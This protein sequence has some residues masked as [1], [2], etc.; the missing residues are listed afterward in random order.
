MF[1]PLFSGRSLPVLIATLL[2]GS[3]FG[4]WVQPVWAQTSPA[5]G[6]QITN[7]GFGSFKAVDAAP[8]DPPVILESNEVVVTVSEVAGITVTNGGVIDDGEVNPGDLVHYRF[9]ITNTGNADTLFFIPDAPASVTNGSFNRGTAPM[10]IIG[11]DPDGA[12]A[13]AAVDLTASNITVPGGGANT[14]TLLG[15]VTAANNGVM[16][17]GATLTLQVP[18]TVAATGLSDGDAITVVMGETTDSGSGTQN[19]PD[20]ADGANTNEI[21]T[22]DPTTG[23]GSDD[24]VNGEREASNSQSTVV[25]IA[26]A[27]NIP[28]PPTSCAFDGNIWYNGP[29]GLYTYNVFSYSNTFQTNLSRTY[30]DIGWGVDGKLYGVDFVSG[31]MR[32]YDI[33]PATGSATLL[34]NAFV[35]SGDTSGGGNS[36][37][38]DEL[39][40]LYFG[41]GTQNHP[42]NARVFRY[43]L[44]TDAAPEL[45]I[46]F[47]DH[48]FAGFP[49]GDFIFIDDF[50]Y[51]AWRP[52]E[53]GAVTNQLL[54]VG[55][56]GPNHEELPSTT[57]TVVGDLTLDNWGLAGNS[58]GNLYVVS[59]NDNSL[60]RVTLAPFAV[61]PIGSLSTQ[62]FGA[63]GLFEAVGIGC[64]TPVDYGDAPDTYGT[65]ASDDSG[66][67]VGPTHTLGGGVY[68]GTF[69]DGETDAATPLDSTGD[70]AEE[71]GITLTPLAEGDTSYTIPAA[72]ITATGTGTLHAWVDFDRSG[73]FEPTEHTSVTVTSGTPA[74]DLSWTGITVAGGDTYARFRLTADTSIDANTPNGAARD[75]EVEDYALVIQP[76]THPAMALVKRITAINGQPTNPNDGT[77]LNVEVNDGIADSDDD[78]SY[79]PANYLMG[80]LN[81]GTIQPG[82]EVEYTIYFLSN[83]DAEA[84][85]VRLCD[86]IQ[87][88]Q[89]FVTGAYSGHD[90]QLEMGGTLYGLTAANDAADRAQLVTVGTLPAGPTCNLPAAA[91][92]IDEGV[93]VVDI[94]GTTGT[95]PGFTTLPFA[96]GPGTPNTAYGFLRFTTRIND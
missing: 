70:G 47:D 63:T 93:L 68:L 46:N 26:A 60:S 15:A 67:G 91:S 58:E 74:A 51:V 12:G 1:T 30:G 8:D 16:P 21:R 90:L 48:G 39:G 94:T 27:I 31:A 29:G 37:S 50:A 73:T 80:E 5:A 83:G 32:L 85:D 20:A 49:S 9:T 72:N 95:P 61:T 59:G 25:A 6:T 22:L 75:G 34:N 33:D 82:D 77:S 28:A 45:W 43:N 2:L 10:Q 4:P 17:A 84:G 3:Q 38:G 53:F 36:L 56:L 35:G 44:Y 87:P 14:A 42:L 19:Q 23:D 62:P 79:W 69:P 78:A 7:K 57:A 86:W 13:G 41:S 71:D 64:S 52:S 65:N 76:G 11:Y 54:R 40:W 89:T 81:G 18:V 96:T 88:N 24:P 66:E 92:N 55:P